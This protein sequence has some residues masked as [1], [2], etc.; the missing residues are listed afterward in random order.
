MI[1]FTCCTHFFDD[2]LELLGRPFSSVE[3]M[4]SHIVE[5][6]N[7]KVKPDDEVYHLGDAIKFDR[8]DIEDDANGYPL[9]ISD[10]NLEKISI[11][12]RLNGKKHLILG[13]YDPSLDKTNFY[14]QEYSKYFLSISNN[15]SLDVNERDLT[16]K[17]FLTHKP[18]HAVKDRFNIVGHIHGAWKIQRNMLNVCQDAHHYYP[19]SFD[20]ILFYYQGISKGYFDENVFCQESAANKTTARII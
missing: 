7:K 4:N 11:L 3:E 15:F 18:I 17:L 13:N 19:V 12:G 14:F 5:N 8:F 16:F 2:R 1:H 20:K 9:K 10:E 6:W